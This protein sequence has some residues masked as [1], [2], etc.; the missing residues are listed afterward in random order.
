MLTDD[1]RRWF[2]CSQFLLD[3][4]VE[5]NYQEISETERRE[6]HAQLSLENSTV[7]SKPLRPAKIIIDYWPSDDGQFDHDTE[8]EEIG[9]VEK[10]WR[11]WR[12]PWQSSR[13]IKL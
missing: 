12:N 11:G 6:L 7:V 10:D 4:W 2:P 8:L 13:S 3:W 5:R 9:M 1:V